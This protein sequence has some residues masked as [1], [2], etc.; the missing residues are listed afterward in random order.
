[1]EK[2]PLARKPQVISHVEVNDEE[3][4]DQAK[5]GLDFWNTRPTPCSTYESLDNPQITH[6]DRGSSFKDH[7]RSSSSLSPAP[8]EATPTTPAKSQNSVKKRQSNTRVATSEHDLGNSFTRPPKTYTKLIG[9]AL[10]DTP[11]HRLTSKEIVQW[12]HENIPGYNKNE[13]TKWENGIGATLSMQQEKEGSTGLWRKVEEDGAKKNQACWYELLP[14]QLNRMLRWDPVLKEPVSPDRTRQ[15]RRTDSNEPA[16]ESDDPTSHLAEENQDGRETPDLGFGNHTGSPTKPNRIHR[17]AAQKEWRPRSFAPDPM[18]VDDG[19]DAFAKAVNIRDDI[20]NLLGDQIAESSDSEP[21]LE[22]RRKLGSAPTS[23]TKL[24]VASTL[25]YGPDDAMNVDG[26]NGVIHSPKVT[27]AGSPV[28]QSA[29][30]RKLVLRP[31][32]ERATLAELIKS[33]AET[34]DYSANSLFNEWPE[35]DP[36]YQVDREAKLLEIKQRPSRKQKFGKPSRDPWLQREP[37][38]FSNNDVSRASSSRS[39]LTLEK[40]NRMNRDA[41]GELYP[42]ESGEGNVKHFDTLE[43]LIQDILP[44]NSLAIV[45]EGRLAYRDGTRNEID[46]SLPRAKH[47][48]KT[49]YA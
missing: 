13:G 32:A 2:S 18:D 1:M 15:N 45:H 44:N 37:G 20:S 27:S 30:R 26:I 5:D 49:G 25:E 21:I 38:S 23:A 29:T 43:S 16:D 14:E 11:G 10:C 7:A 3:E 39:S 24:Q 42:W 48:Y 33:D 4:D 19:N 9:M 12:I 35:Y 28:E 36:A 41:A 47:I 34:T 17:E 40:T 46:G 22:S 6:N 8:V 31:A